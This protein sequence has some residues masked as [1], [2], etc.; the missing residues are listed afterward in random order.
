MKVCAGIVTYNPDIDLL[1]KNISQ[2]ILQVDRV[3]LCDN[4]SINISELENVLNTFEKVKLIIFK[5][6]KGIATA[7]NML[8]RWAVQ[9]RYD[10]ILTL[11]QDS[12]C[13]KEL[14]SQLL[15]DVKKDTGIVA[16]R[17]I[18]KD[19][20][21]YLS[22]PKSQFEYVEWV[23]TSASLTNLVAWKTVNGFDEW[24]FIDGV[25]YDFCI[26]LRRSGYMIIQ[27]NRVTLYH[28]LGKLKC[29]RLFGRTIYV[30]NHSPFRYYYMV[31]NGFYLKKKLHRGTPWIKT[32]KLLL[33]I[34]LFEGDKMKKI[35]A[36]KKALSY[37]NKGGRGASNSASFHL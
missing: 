5:E 27:D 1:K 7:L 28:E 14:V 10:W 15:R 4:G 37:A 2:I 23:I 29:R 24:L 11:D 32:F 6:N 12:I 13:P 17:I 26:R 31:R 20:E 34:I 8:C 9:H 16:P 3:V 19:N 21:K 30:T 22:K 33:K 36:I 35:E 18:Y 25:D